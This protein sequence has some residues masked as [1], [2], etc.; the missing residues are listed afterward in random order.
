MAE[1]EKLDIYACSLPMPTP[2]KPVCDEWTTEIARHVDA[3]AEHEIYLVGHSLGTP[4]ILRYLELPSAQK[5]AGAILVSGPI[6]KLENKKIEDFLNKE[7]DFKTIKS[8]AGKVCVIHGDNDTLV[9][10]GHAKRLAKGLAAEL[11]IVKNGGHLNGSSGWTSLPQAL[12]AL[13]KM[14]KA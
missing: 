13:N 10:V 4:A 2:E 3:S 9:P 12:E 11:V 14:F 8:K 5:I 6:E 1:L 7:F